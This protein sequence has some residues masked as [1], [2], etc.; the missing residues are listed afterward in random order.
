MARANTASPPSSPWSS[1]GFPPKIAAAVLRRLPSQA[2]RVRFAAVCRPWRAAAARYPL[3]PLPWLALPDGTFFSFPSSAALRFNPA[4][5]AGGY[6]GS[7]DDWLLFDAIG[8]AGEDGYL[9][10][11]PFTGATA[12]LP[13]LSRVRFAVGDG[14]AALPWRGIAD[15]QRAPRG[16]TVR[17]LAICPGDRLVAALVGDGQLGKIAMCRAGGGAGSSWVM[18]GHDAWR[19]ITDMAFYDG[20]VYAVDDTGELFAMPTGVDPRTGEPTV[21]WAR[22]VVKASSHGAP[23]RR[24]RRKQQASPS[25]RYLFVHGGRLMMVHRTVVGNGG[26]TKFAVFVADLAASRW[27]EVASVGGDTALFVGRWRTLA[28][29]V[30]LYGMPG[31]RIHF[32][33]DHAFPRGCPGSFGSYDMGDGKTYSL[34]P[35]QPPEFFNSGGGD[36]PATWL[37]PRD[38]EQE[39]SRW[40]DLP[41]DVVGLVLRHLR[42]REERLSLSEVCRD[43]CSSA[44]QHLRRRPR[45]RTLL[46][47]VAP[48]PATAYLA[49][50]N[51]RMFRFPELTS[52]LPDKKLACFAGVAAGAAC[53]DWIFF[54]DDGGLLR[55]AS[56]FTGKTT[57]LPSFH[58]IR[59]HGGHV[60]IVNDAAAAS[61]AA[62]WRARCYDKPTMAVRKLV[63][64]PDGG[65]GGFVAAA[66]L[67]GQHLAKVA[68]CSTETFSWSHSAGDRWRRYDD[69]TLVGGRL[70]A[71]TA[72]EDLL[73]LDVG[74]DGDT[75]EPFVSGVERVVEGDRYSPFAG[76][77]RYLVAASGGGELLMVRRRAEEDGRP[78]FAVFR[79]DLASARWE[80]VSRLGRGGG[81][82]L[83][84]GRLCSRAVRGRRYLPGGQI[85][86]LP[87]ECPAKWVPRR[88]PGHNA[89]VYNMLDGKVTHLL[90]RQRH[91]EEGPWQATWLFSSEMVH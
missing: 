46:A 12:R 10:A 90:P 11:N 37:F 89:A 18:S 85:F 9:L 76:T 66:I 42:C 84:V 27:S 59:A 33:D 64:C 86:F 4:A 63:V 30:S 36:T 31:N 39:V 65:G 87:D 55:L 73:A 17:K 53:D 72:G 35:P 70:Y 61:E 23:S 20:K 7:C 47:A 3:P 22:C 45:P 81:E 5:A 77:A 29:R 43:W 25:M 82:A 80:P 34:L 74:F 54:H 78:R 67:G 57:L 60:E 91:D 56:P 2:D 62:L 49:L 40:C 68:L 48:S 83:F 21:A 26:A 51:G 13:S 24:R 44:R 58:G 16:A 52:R 15:D 69:L 14:S 71:L 28:R 32:L 19:G 79:A 50:P 75:G 41:C 8:G 6:L 1:S 38:R 88:R